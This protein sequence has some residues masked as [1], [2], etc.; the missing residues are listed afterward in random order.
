[1]KAPRRKVIKA[2]TY[3]GHGYKGFPKTS[4]TLLLECGHTIRWGYPSKTDLK[5][6]A[7]SRVQCGPCGR[8]SNNA[9]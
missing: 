1:M 3:H 2:E 5:M 8:L 7:G 6:K 4:V 9:P